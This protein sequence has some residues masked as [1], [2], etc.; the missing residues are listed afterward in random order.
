[1]AVTLCGGKG[2]DELVGC[3]GALKCQVGGTQ[4][5]EM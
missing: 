5:P 4:A 2:L 3:V 1:M